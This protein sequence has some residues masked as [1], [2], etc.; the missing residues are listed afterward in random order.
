MIRAARDGD[1]PGLI[2][3]WQ[4][5]F[6]DTHE[7]T[8]FYF[9][10][11]HRA[12]HMLVAEREGAV[13]GMLTMLPVA[14]VFGGRALPGRY[15]FGL[16]AA[17]RFRGQGIGTALLAAAHERMRAG[18]DAAAV[19]VPSDPG[20]FSYYRKRGYRTLFWQDRLS[21]PA[22]NLPPPDAAGACAPLG[23]QAYFRL[24]ESAF[25]KSGLF[26]RWDE[27]ALA[28][29]LNSASASGGAA[30]RL[31]LGDARAGA[32]CEARDG[33]VRVTELALHGMGPMDAMALVHRR[34]GARAYE[35]RAPQGTLPGAM[36][37]PF[38]MIRAFRRLPALKGG[39]PWLNLA[40][41]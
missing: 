34:L 35:L 10:G 14:L 3:L 2:G 31:E 13:A 38:G 23:A 29:I 21:L 37:V 39:P 5:A 27:E 19:L 7:E 25:Q 40:K 12:E 32:V 33:G 18:G 4:E 1:L 41:D 28:F 6:G 9:R 22:G 11:R 20:L 36:S 16:A 26:V 8:L 24:R 30:L 17:Q 15:L